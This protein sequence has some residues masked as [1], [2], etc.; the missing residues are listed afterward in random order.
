MTMTMTMTFFAVPGLLSG[1]GLRST[2]ERASK[3]VADGPAV[4]MSLFHV[5]VHCASPLCE[6]MCESMWESVHWEWTVPIIAHH[7]PEPL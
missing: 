4:V 3:A 2:D 1:Q 5:R 6:S 7:L